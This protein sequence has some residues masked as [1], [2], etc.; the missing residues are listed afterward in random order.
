MTMHIQSLAQAGRV[1]LF[2]MLVTMS[3]S[4]CG[5]PAEQDDTNVMKAEQ[6]LS[7]S[8]PVP[9]A[10]PVANTYQCRGFD[11][12]AR[13][14]LVK[15]RGGSWTHIG[16]FPTIPHGECGRSGLDYCK[17]KGLDDYCWGIKIP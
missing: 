1:G 7:S 14:C 12:G 15:C 13:F 5:E 2:S 16:S 6:N 10:S 11:N 4:A 3:L 9:P 8:N 17:A